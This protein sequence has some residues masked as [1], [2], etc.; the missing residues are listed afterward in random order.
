MITF[1][2]LGWYN[3]TEKNVKTEWQKTDISLSTN[4]YRIGA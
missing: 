4:L 3:H 1:F 2:R